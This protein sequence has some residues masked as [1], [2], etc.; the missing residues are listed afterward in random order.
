MSLRSL[1]TLAVTATPLLVAPTDAIQ[2]RMEAVRPQV[3]HSGRSEEEEQKVQ[4]AQNV[5]QDGNNDQVLN[6]IIE[7]QLQADELMDLNEIDEIGDDLVNLNEEE[8]KE[9]NE[10]AMNSAR[11]RQ[12]NRQLDET[13]MARAQRLQEEALQRSLANTG[14]TINEVFDYSVFDQ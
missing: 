11:F 10:A 4:P 1:S 13:V 5:N 9:P 12:V 7:N 3:Q 8:L 2:V 14:D 6:N